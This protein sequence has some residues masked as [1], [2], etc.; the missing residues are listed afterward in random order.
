MGGEGS[1]FAQ[2]TAQDP[3]SIVARLAYGDVSVLLTGDAEADTE[4]RLLE[5]GGALGATVLKVAHHGSDHATSLRF[6][7]AVKPKVGVVSCGRDNHYGHPALGLRGR[8]RARRVPLYRTDLGGTVAFRTDGTHWAVASEGVGPT[9]LGP[10]AHAPPPTTLQLTVL[11]NVNTADV[12]ALVAL[13][14]IGPKK[15]A[16]IVAARDERP[17]AT[18]DDLIRV[19]GIGPKTLERLRSLV[20]VGDPSAPPR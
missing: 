7:D 3:D 5:D 19:R 13:P 14:G 12:D 4:Q 17:F 11:I 8:L 6:L 9:P 18:V 1:A 15:A 10:G 2:A 20:T 16:A